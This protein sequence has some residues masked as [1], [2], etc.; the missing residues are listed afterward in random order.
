M[1]KL[2]I[3]I[4]TNVLTSAVMKPSGIEGTVVEA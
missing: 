2:C 1:K 4:D 3:V